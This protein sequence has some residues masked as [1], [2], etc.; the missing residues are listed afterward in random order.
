MEPVFVLLSS[1]CLFALI[2]VNATLQRTTE[3]LWIVNCFHRQKCL[4]TKMMTTGKRLNRYFIGVLYCSKCLFW[5]TPFYQGALKPKATLFATCFL[6]ICFL[7]FTM[8]NHKVIW[9]RLVN[10]YTLYRKRSKTWVGKP[11]NYY[12][13]IVSV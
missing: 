1:V 7:F 10:L 12:K 13:A 4:W 3:I 9:S 6:W 11:L 8:N 5:Y 2:L